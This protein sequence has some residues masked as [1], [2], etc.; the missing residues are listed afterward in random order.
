MVGVF[1]V[2]ILHPEISVAL[3]VALIASLH[4]HMNAFGV[5]MDRKLRA[6]M[7][8]GSHSMLPMTC[9]SRNLKHGNQG[10]RRSCSVW[11]FGINLT[12]C[13]HPMQLG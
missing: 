7:D 6:R 10:W 12:L 3:T 8:P 4:H 9:G 11:T 13:S 5:A 2:Y 1:D